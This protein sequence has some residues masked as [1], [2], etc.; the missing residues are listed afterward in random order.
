MPNPSN[1]N[2]ITHTSGEFPFRLVPA[3]LQYR[4]ASKTAVNIFSSDHI[5]KFVSPALQTL[6]KFPV[7]PSVMRVG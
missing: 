1:L 7:A 5:P 3:G 4:L 2:V 6:Q